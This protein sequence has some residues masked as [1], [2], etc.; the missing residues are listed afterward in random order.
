VSARAANR[1]RNALATPD[2]RERWRTVRDRLWAV[3]EPHLAPD[4]RVAIVG[5]GNA[6]DIPLTR[7]LT[8]AR[9]VDLIDLD[10]VAMKRA[11][12]C[13]SPILRTRAR[14]IREDVTGGAA[15]AIVRAA[16]R[17]RAPRTT[18][19]PEDPI[20]GGAYDLVIGDLFYSQLLY[21][22]LLDLGLAADRIDHTLRQYGQQLC[23]SVVARL[24]ASA[25]DGVVVHIHDA[26]GWWSNHNPGGS[27]DELL[28]LPPRDAL[29]R[30][31]DLDGPWG[32]DVA[33]SVTALGVDV[34]EVAT[35]PWPFA[36]DVDYFVYTLLTRGS[37]PKGRTDASR[38]ERLP[39]TTAPGSDS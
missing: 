6:D 14:V 33:G 28:A 30:L 8:R 12:Y 22:A 39:D 27:I 18:R 35:W 26:L 37:D 13:E 19:A 29:A 17:S 16:R 23:G 31:H 38:H 4:A 34:A 21:P 3:L 10:Q 5:A 11:L 1:A 20:G 9:R 24:H 2:R 36:D 15:D 7:I 25:P 32:C